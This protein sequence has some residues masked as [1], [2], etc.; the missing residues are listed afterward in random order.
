MPL[1]LPRKRRS[2]VRP[3]RPPRLRP[4]GEAARSSGEIPLPPARWFAA[5]RRASLGWFARHG[6]DLPWRQSSDPYAVMVSE[7]M[8][9]QTTVATVA[10]RWQRFLAAFPTVEH[11]ARADESE[12]L[13]AWEGLGYYRR[14]GQLRAA[15]Q[16]I[17]ADHA[18]RVPDDLTS[19]ARLPGLGRYSASAVLCF[20]RGQSLPIIEANTRRL[21]ARLLGFR[22]EASSTAAD[23]LFWAAA[24]QIVGRSRNPRNVNLALMDLGALVCRPR[25]PQC[26]RCPLAAHCVAWAE[27]VQNELPGK[28]EKA[29]LQQRHE[30]AVVIRRERKVLLVRYGKGGR[31][32][33]LWDFPRVLLADGAPAVAWRPPQSPPDK[34]RRLFPRST[35]PR[36]PKRSGNSTSLAAKAGQTGEAAATPDS[37][38]LLARRVNEWLYRLLGAS[39]DDESGS[40]GYGGIE[41]KIV[42]ERHLARWSHRVTRFQIT[43]DCLAAQCI[44]PEDSNASGKRPSA[45][46]IFSETEGGRKCEGRE[47]GS[48]PP[49]GEAVSQRQRSCSAAKTIALNRKASARSSGDSIGPWCETAWVE[50][51]TLAHFPMPSTARRLVQLVVAAEDGR[52]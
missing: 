44:A 52:A 4:R 22:A 11:L 40:S 3:D 35:A 5:V 34:Q 24:E 42:V 23:R 7:L 32:A 12:V 8:L 26:N 19:L 17:V 2:D 14:A 33:G 46:P 21:W 50:P 41:G 1:D 10:P 9:Q 36:G 38:D 45:A 31:W 20:A 6:R 27:G 49:P 15:A 13:R 43:L 48:L 16:R 18:G 29:A 51:E 47:E 39:A 37:S 30:A 25:Q 28:R